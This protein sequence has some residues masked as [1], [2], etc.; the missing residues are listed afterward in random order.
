VPKIA[1]FVTVA[2][3]DQAANAHRSPP[4]SVNPPELG[5]A[6]WIKIHRYARQARPQDRRSRLMARNGP[7]I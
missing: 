2:V 5:E 1:T 3:E 7:D 6:A 4:N